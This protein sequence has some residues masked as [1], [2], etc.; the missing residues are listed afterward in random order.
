MRQTCFTD[1]FSVTSKNKYFL[2]HKGQI[3]STQGGGGRYS[4]PVIHIVS[5]SVTCPCSISLS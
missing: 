2:S 3:V 4:F 5:L 1:P